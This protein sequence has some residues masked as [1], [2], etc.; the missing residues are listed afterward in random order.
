MSNDR[1]DSA[2]FYYLALKP[3]GWELG[4]RDPAYP[5]G[6]RFL[7]TGA[8]P[9]FPIGT[10]EHVEVTQATDGNGHP[11]FTVKA[12]VNGIPVTLA[13]FTDTE[14][15]Y[16]SGKVGNYN[17]DSQGMYGWTEVDQ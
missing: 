6:Q 12:T 9:S 16:L 11:T 15:P 2:H 14:R 4:K 17:E 8:T 5:G 10:W 13:T 1:N 3:S 7:A